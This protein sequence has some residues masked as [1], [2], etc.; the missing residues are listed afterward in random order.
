[1]PR[2]WDIASANLLFAVA[3]FI[4]KPGEHETD[5]IY[6]IQ[7]SS[8]I[9][10]TWRYIYIRIFS[11]QFSVFKAFGNDKYPL[12]SSGALRPASNRH[13]Q[14]MYVIPDN[15]KQFSFKN[16]YP[17]KITPQG[18]RGVPRIL[19]HLQSY[20]FRELKPI[21]NFRTLRLPLLGA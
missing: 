10:R 7:S 1:M 6:L 13:Q 11:S 12:A 17:K 4:I 8:D 3:P 15:S 14:K 21:Q 19:F 20:Y 16:N 5:L 2:S 9:S 18:G